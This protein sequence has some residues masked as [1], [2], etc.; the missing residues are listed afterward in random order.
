M[1][2][3]PLKSKNLLNA[4]VGVMS[5][6]SKDSPGNTDAFDKRNGS[7]TG[8]ITEVVDA[9]LDTSDALSNALGMKSPYYKIGEIN[10][11]DDS[12]M[13]SAFGQNALGNV[14]RAVTSVAGQFGLVEGYQN[15]VVIDGFGVVSGN[16]D[17]K[18]TENPVLFVGGSIS[19]GRY[20]TPNTVQMKVFVSNYYNDDLIGMG[21]DALGSALG[22]GSLTGMAKNIA[23]YGGNSRAQQALY[24]LRKL[25]ETGR[26]FVLYTPHGRYENMMIESLRPITDDK[27]VDMLECDITF[28]EVIMYEI[29]RTDGNSTTIPSRQNVGSDSWMGQRLGI[30]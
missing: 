8:G 6:M 5:N 2:Y 21:I 4:N 24:N 18:F 17:I 10:P 7:V 13:F 3:S 29:Y 16:I 1:A 12:Q 9:V 11:L 27:N 19:D 15:G 20:R 30:F 23:L 14:V 25:Q 22:L 28:K 26:P